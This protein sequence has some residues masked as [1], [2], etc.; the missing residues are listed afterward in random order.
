MSRRLNRLPFRS[1][2]GMGSLQESFAERRFPD[3]V[4]VVLLDP[5]GDRRV[6]M[7]VELVHQA[8]DA[9]IELD[10]F[11]G[12]VVAGRAAGAV[13]H[14]FVAAQAVLEQPQVPALCIS[15]VADPAAEEI[16]FQFR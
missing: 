8:M 4:S 13:G 15:A 5:D 2:F 9:A 1:F 12:L 16:I 10:V 6:G 11:V 7:V 3:R 14:L